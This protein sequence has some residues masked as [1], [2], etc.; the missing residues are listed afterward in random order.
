M[1]GVFNLAHGDLRTMTIRKWLTTAIVLCLVATIGG[2]LGF[3]ALGYANQNDVV[4]ASDKKPDFPDAPQRPDKPQPGTE[5]LTF[6]EFDRL[7]KKLTTMSTEKVWSIPW[8]LS[9]REARALA[10]KENKPV[11]LW[12]SSNGGTHPLG[13]C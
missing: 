3:L 4:Q 12:I 11:F 5:R 9:V 13:P 7:H 8:Q 1:F 6:A 2:G 10:A